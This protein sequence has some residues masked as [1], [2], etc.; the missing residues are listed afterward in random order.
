M[1]RH[2]HDEAL[3]A[4]G[5][6]I[7][8]Y[9]CIHLCTHRVVKVERHDHDEALKA[10][11]NEMEHL[12]GM[13]VEYM[14]EPEK[15]QEKI[16]SIG[17]RYHGCGMQTRHVEPLGDALAQTMRD[18]A[19]D[20][21]TAEMIEAFKW[22]YRTSIQTPLIKVLQSCEDDIAG[23]VSMHWDEIQS[24]QTTEQLGDAFFSALE[25]FAPDLLHLFKRP[26]KIQ[27]VIFTH[28][29]EMLVNS[30]YDPEL[31]FSANKL[32]SVRHIKYGVKAENLK[33]YGQVCMYI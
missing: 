21:M 1:E 14:F 12:I 32:L 28:V 10:L 2:D 25:N 22:M 31:F 18:L 33:P 30:S 6:H 24:K 26:K 20:L 8:I 4:S 19:P 16:V 7:Y 11:G 17:I 15:Q 27:V 13:S 3:K 5:I 9:V 23:L 29:M